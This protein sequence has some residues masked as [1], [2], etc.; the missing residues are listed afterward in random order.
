MRFQLVQNSINEFFSC[1]E[2]Q[3]WQQDI[4]YGTY[5][6]RRKVTSMIYQF[7]DLHQVRYIHTSYCTL[8]GFCSW[9]IGLGQVVPAQ[10]QVRLVDIN[11]KVEEATGAQVMVRCPSHS[12]HLFFIVLLFLD[13]LYVFLTLFSLNSQH[14]LLS[15]L[16]ILVL[17]LFI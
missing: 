3:F 10:G 17:Y 6:K 2:N 8:R 15:S 11:P 7:K 9:L 14:F 12:R 1:F 4:N 16:S 13:H 5:C